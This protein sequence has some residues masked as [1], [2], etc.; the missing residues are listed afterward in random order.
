[1][2]WFR[3]YKDILEIYDRYTEDI[4]QNILMIFEYIRYL[5]I[6]SS[7]YEVYILCTFWGYKM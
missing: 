4:S 3:Y 1:M 2:V 6:L 7:S 5:Y